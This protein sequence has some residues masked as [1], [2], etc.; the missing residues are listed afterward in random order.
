MKYFCMYLEED[1][2]LS[3]FSVVGNAYKKD[4]SV[5]F[6]NCRLKKSMTTSMAN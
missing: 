5:S 3:I 6:G 1:E 2:V 4:V